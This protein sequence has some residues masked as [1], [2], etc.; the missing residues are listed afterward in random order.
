ME[1]LSLR[2]HILGENLQ[3]HTVCVQCQT[4][5]VWYSS[6][7]RYTSYCRPSHEN[8]WYNSDDRSVS[9]LRTP[10]KTSA[11]YLFYN[12]LQNMSSISTAK[13]GTSFVV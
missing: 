13:C 2:V 1:G 6:G 7:G 9:R 4:T 12:S 3:P 11:A 5:L 10:V 8:V